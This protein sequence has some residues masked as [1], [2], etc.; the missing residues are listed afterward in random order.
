MQQLASPGFALPV[1]SVIGNRDA[2]RREVHADLV[3]AASLGL[4]FEQ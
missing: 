2:Y 1:D 3:R 4:H